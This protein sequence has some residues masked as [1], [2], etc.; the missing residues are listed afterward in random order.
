MSEEKK[1]KEEGIYARCSTC[2]QPIWDFM[3]ENKKIFDET[4]MCGAC[5]TGEASTYIDEL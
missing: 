1:E 2:G 3:E 5:A 4:D